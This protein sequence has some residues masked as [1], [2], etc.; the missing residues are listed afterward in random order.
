VAIVFDD[1]MEPLIQRERRILELFYSLLKSCWYIGDLYFLLLESSKLHD[2]QHNLWCYS[3]VRK[4]TM[5][6]YAALTDAICSPQQ[7]I[8]LVGYKNEFFI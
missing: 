2:F 7:L 4:L 5:K 3:A 6:E 8:T 1:I